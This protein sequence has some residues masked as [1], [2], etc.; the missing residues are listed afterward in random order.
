MKKYFVILLCLFFSANIFA[1]TTSEVKS[2]VNHAY[3]QWCTAIGKAKGNP[4]VVTQF[5]APGAT[6]V[7]TL[8]HKILRN[9]NHGL[10]EYFAHLTSH[11]D[12]RC[13]PEKNRIHLHGK[14]VTNSGLYEFSFMDDGHRKNIPA[15]FT[16]V[17]EKIDGK[18]LIINHHSSK[19]PE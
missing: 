12:I 8:S 19:M 14:T 7:P 5:Y 2:Q 10:D 16:F 4:K 18:W 15:R 9:K 13:I 17:Y 1:A 6:L 11:K 3:H